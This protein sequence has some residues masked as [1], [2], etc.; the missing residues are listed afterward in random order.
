[1]TMPTSIEWLSSPA[2]D[3]RFFSDEGSGCVF[4]GRRN[5]SD[6]Q[7]AKRV[8]SL[9]DF[10]RIAT[11]ESVFLL[12]DDLRIQASIDLMRA[13]SAGIEDFS[14]I[15]FVC[16]T[17]QLSRKLGEWTP[18]EKLRSGLWLVAFHE[19]DSPDELVGGA[20]RTIVMQHWLG[21]RHYIHAPLPILG[22]QYQLTSYQAKHHRVLAD[23]VGR[24][25]NVVRKAF[26]PHR[27][28]EVEGRDVQSV[29]VDTIDKLSTVQQEVAEVSSRDSPPT[30]VVQL[31]S[32]I[33]K[34]GELSK[35]LDKINSIAPVRLDPIQ[36]AINI[37]KRLTESV[38]MI[39]ASTWAQWR[40][41]SGTNPA[42]ALSKH[43]AKLR[44]FAVRSGRRD[45]YP[46][47]QFRPENGEPLE[48][49]EKILHAV[50]EG[51]HGWPLL[52]WFDARN[53]LLEG[54]KPLDLIATSPAAVLDA[55]ERFYSRD[56]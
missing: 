4:I 8:A 26:G 28:L 47:F 45:M 13:S 52:S 48:I 46:A 54:K 6:A 11:A 3:L 44:V 25:S 19:K 37:R 51:A 5:A 50:P 32:A 35:G 15:V 56:D 55:A 38:Q 53:E 40:G 36:N 31:E 7:L 49:M 43:K 30:N 41:T 2:S 34:L 24:L 21:T 23:V 14:S 20:L 42:A 10:A 22:K 29:V 9:G 27:Y 18:Q 1:M 16:L 33:S 17:P 12:N 39:D